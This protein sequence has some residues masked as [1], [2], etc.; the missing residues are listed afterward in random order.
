MKRYPTYRPTDIS[1]LA[2]IPTHWNLDKILSHFYF[3]SVKVSD[4]DYPALSVTKDGILPQLETAVKTDNGDNRKL[5]KK[6]DYVVNSRSDRKG[7]C[8]VSSYD[9]SV[10]LINHVLEPRNINISYVHF[11]MRSND[12]VEEFYRMGRGIVADLWT[13]RFSEMKN[14]FIPIPP[15]AE[16]EQIVKYPETKTLRIDDYK[17]ERERVTAA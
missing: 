11:L 2:E 7:S 12:F 3:R 5:V 9:G 16:Q 17:R 4:K 14:I 8:G 6:G 10:S 1:W 13:T 15:F